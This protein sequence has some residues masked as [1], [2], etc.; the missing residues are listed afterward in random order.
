MGGRKHW[1]CC[2]WC[3]DGGGQKPGEGEPEELRTPRP[4]TARTR[5]PGSAAPHSPPAQSLALRS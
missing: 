1:T 3:E 5:T 2:H 4:E